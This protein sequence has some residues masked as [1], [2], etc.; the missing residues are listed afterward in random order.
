MGR[1]WSIDVDRSL[2]AMFDDPLCPHVLRRALTGTL[3]WQVRNGTSVRRALASPRIAPQWVAALLALG[4]TVVTD[5]GEVPLAE[6]DASAVSDVA[7]ARTLQVTLD[8][9]QWGE[10]HVARTPAD[11]PIVAVVAAVRL[12]GDVVKE[13]RVALTGVWSEA[14]R[15]AEAAAQLAGGPLD[16]ERIQTVAEAVAQ[17][18]AP[19]GDFRGSVVYRRAMAGTLTRRALS[20]LHSFED[21]VAAISESR[22]AEPPY[23]DLQTRQSEASEVTLTINGEEKTLAVGRAERL[24]DA[25]RA[26]GYTSVKYGCGTGDCG[27]CTVLLDGRPVH[28]CQMRALDAAG[29]EITTVEALISNLQSPT[30]TLHPIQ[31]AFIDTGA[32]QCGYCTPAQILTALALLNRNPDPS[33][34]EI[35][36]ALSG[37]LCR[38]TGYVK[39]VQAVQRAARI[40]RSADVGQEGILPR[41]VTPPDM[42]SLDVVGKGEPKVDGVKLAAGRPVFTD[43]VKLDGMLYGALLTSPHAYARITR[44]DA[45][46]ARALHG[47]HAVLTYEDIPRIKHASGGQ[48]Y[49]Q[50]PPFDQVCLDDTVRYVG[51]RVAVVAAE[52]PELA[53]RALRSIEVEYEVLEPVLDGEAAMRDGAPIVHDEPDTEGIY[54]AEHNVVHHIEVEV[55]PPLHPPRERGGERGGWKEADHVFEGTY[56]TAQQQHAHIEPHACIT[57]WDEDGRLVVRSSTQ[58]PFHIR[59]L[60][61]PLIGLPVKQIRVVKPR[62]GGGFG[63][64]QEMVLEDLCAHL[65]IATGRPVRMMYTRRQEFTSSR[66]RHPQVMR[67]RLGVTDDMEVVATELDLIGDTGAYGTHGLTVQMVAGQ[68]ALTLYNTPYSR[69]T[70]D[71]VYTNKPTPG[72]FRGYGAMQ[73]FFGLETL[74][75]EIADRMGWDVVAFKRKNWIKEGDV[76]LLSKALGEG[77]EG[78]EQKIESSGLEECVRVGLEATDWYNKRGSEVWRQEG[79]ETRRGIGMAVMLHGSGVAGLDMGSA[80]IK[81]NDDGSFNLLIGATDLGTGSD[82]ILAQIAAEVLGVEVADIIVYSSDTDFTPFDKGAY[83]SSTTYISG[84]AVRQA[85]L[86]VADQIKAHA[87]RMLGMSPP[88]PAGTSPPRAGGTEGGLDEWVLHDRQVI[89]PDGTALTLAQVAL[90]SLH[91]QEQHQI[92]AS[93]SRMSTA[94]PPPFAAQFAEVAV[95]TE[96]GQV[97]VERILMAVDAGR[98]INPITAS[99]QVEGGLQQGVGFAMCEE[100]VYDEQ[101]RLVNARLGPYHVYKCDEMPEMEVIF[102]QTD[103]PT[104]PFGAKSVAEIPLDGVAPAIADAIHD[105]TGVWVR[106]VPFT[107]E[108]VWRALREA[109]LE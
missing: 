13:V 85:A 74:M 88:C 3:S 90:S 72:A 43:D 44:I 76:L 52:T 54:D 105:A 103:E 73:C 106:E 34:G 21:G 101:G 49:P 94:S 40:L 45:G 60:L 67:Y 20:N 47:V 104:G 83:A 5:D 66:S 12:E 39:I 97:T 57:Y 6:A 96:T 99:G 75:S 23:S 25:L 10:A 81:M 7:G 4:A 19:A 84:E 50:P 22:E 70:C 61:A 31:Q 91:Q 38:C 71:V 98:V 59:R 95:D 36:E 46:E 93:A 17:E 26:A 58:V 1:R 41:I 79:R 15:P 92:V 68:K 11:E 64:K 2:Q 87:A 55:S 62:I 37:V 107:P 80:T 56:R 30:P 33:E 65:T 51:D 29:R 32:I 48:S 86:K 82:T 69:F 78:Y 53:R 14:V 109:D 27:A 18:V 35:R 8:G 16:A 102:V 108:R 77:R 9:L 100:M 63:N 42:A 28:S 24:L 89:A